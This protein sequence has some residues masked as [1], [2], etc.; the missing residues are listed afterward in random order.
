MNHG[1]LS[2][3]SQ[4]LA[5]L[6]VS[7]PP[8]EAVF[9][10][11]ADALLRA[12]LSTRAELDYAASFV[13]ERGPFLFIPS[14]RSVISERDI[15]RGLLVMLGAIATLYHTGM[16]SRLDLKHPVKSEETPMGAYFITGYDETTVAEKISAVDVL[17]NNPLTAMELAFR[18]LYFPG[19]LA[20]TQFAAAGSFVDRGEEDAHVPV[21]FL[22]GGNGGD[23]LVLSSF[24]R[25]HHSRVTL[26]PSCGKRVPIPCSRH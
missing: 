22:P 17:A 18:L 20:E 11:Q 9:F 2:P 10:H 23:T 1:Q 5:L 14:G 16:A 6:P 24:L 15:A 26:F 19:A 12:G 3:A 25:R 8:A 13:P 7:T 4:R 21:F